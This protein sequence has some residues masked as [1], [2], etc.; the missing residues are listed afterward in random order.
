VLTPKPHAH[1]TLQTALRQGSSFSLRVPL[2]RSSQAKRSRRFAVRALAARRSIISTLFTS[3]AQARPIPTHLSHRKPPSPRRP[4]TTTMLKMKLRHLNVLEGELNA[5]S[6]E[7][8]RVS[9][10]VLPYTFLRARACLLR[11]TLTP[12]PPPTLLCPRRSPS[13]SVPI[14]LKEIGPCSSQP[15]PRK[16][17]TRSSGGLVSSACGC[18]Y[19]L[20]RLR[21]SLPPNLWP[22]V[23]KTFFLCVSTRPSRV[24]SFYLATASSCVPST[25]PHAVL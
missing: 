17:T 7:A 20:S 22:V 13:P 15:L 8:L 6:E 18:L 21:L 24:L 12:F 9:G 14:V 25:S 5:A 11:Q 3:L 4:S 16:D 23:V 19:A 2:F 1:H 10:R